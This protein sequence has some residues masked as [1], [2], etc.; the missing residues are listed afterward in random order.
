VNGYDGRGT[1]FPL[2]IVR[3]ADFAIDLVVTDSLGVAVNL[4]TATIAG[5]IYTTA[6]TSTVVMTPVV[7]GVGSNVITLSL[8][9][10]QTAALTDTAYRWTLWVTRGSDIRPWLAGRV[11][12]ATATSG[13][14]PTSGTQNLTVDSDLTV[15]VT[16]AVVAASA[17][18]TIQSAAPTPADPGDLWIDSDDLALY[19]YYDDGDSLQWVA[20][21][22]PAGPTGPTG[23]TG[24]TG[25]AG[26]SVTVVDGGTAVSPFGGTTAIDGGTA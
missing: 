1:R 15:A 3:G 21:S 26:S 17:V 24:A 10:T 16:V 23:A 19:T 11:N 5:T 8:T 2:T 12:V 13:G 25:P 22:G 4:S 20:L 7:S 6:G 14:S 9:E 18:A